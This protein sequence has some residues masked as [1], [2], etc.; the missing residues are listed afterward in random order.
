MLQ[1]HL[2]PGVQMVLSVLTALFTIASH[3]MPSSLIRSHFKQ[4]PSC[5]RERQKPGAPGYLT[6]AAEEKNASFP[7]LAQKRS[8]SKPGSHANLWANHLVRWKLISDW[9]K[10]RHLTTPGL[11]STPLKL[12]ELGTEKF[13]KGRKSGQTNSKSM[14][15]WSLVSQAPDTKREGQSCTYSTERLWSQNRF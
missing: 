1:A 13:P 14:S 12:H 9:P 4:L 8:L 5:S 10:L 11:V 2:N 3:C 15:V 7:K 6:P